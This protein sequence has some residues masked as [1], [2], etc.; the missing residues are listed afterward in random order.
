MQHFNYYTILILLHLCSHW[1]KRIIKY[2][3]IEQGNISFLGYMQ[4]QKIC[5]CLMTPIETG[6]SVIKQCS[7][8]AWCNVTTS[9][10]YGSAGSS[11][12]CFLNKD[13][14]CLQLPTFRHLLHCLC[15]WEAPGKIAI[16]DHVTI[17]HCDNQKS[18]SVAKYPEMAAGTSGTGC[19]YY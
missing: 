17:G 6:I 3:W 15:L 5:P 1:I 14:I 4:S 9:F 11:Q 19:N 10:S 12:L 16:G 13:L 7:H 18:G 2:L 8:K